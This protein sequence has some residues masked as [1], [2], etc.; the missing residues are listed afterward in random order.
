MKRSA[1][2]ILAVAFGGPALA[3]FGWGGI[4]G[5][6]GYGL[7]W[8][9]NSYG[10]Q[11]GNVIRSEG[12]ADLDR[13]QAAINRESARSQEIQNRLDHTQTFFAMRRINQQYAD[14]Q[15]AR[16]RVNPD[17]MARMARKMEPRRLTPSQLD[18]VTGAIHWP[19]HLLDAQYNSER[20][21]LDQL[22][23]HRSDNSGG[24]GS[25]RFAQ[26][27]RL[28]NQMLEKL[29]AHI[30]DLDTADYLYNRSFLTSLAWEARFPPQ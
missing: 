18:P 24:I 6:G 8:G 30:Q 17:D 5:W 7:G 14:E 3:Q 25:D 15:Y 13:S 29:R 27:Q 11:L 4:G 10:D 19:G 16:T 21:A 26:I 12:Q 9:T 1:A 22:F 23:V 20:G 2:I 28:T